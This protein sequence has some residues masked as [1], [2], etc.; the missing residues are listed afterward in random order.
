MAFQQDLVQTDTFQTA[1]PLVEGQA[2]IELDQSGSSIGAGVA[3]G[4]S[5]IELETIGFY[6]DGLSIGAGIATGASTL[7]LESVA[8]GFSGI[9]SSGES[10]IEF[11]AYGITGVNFTTNIELEQ[12][13]SGFAGRVGAAD[14]TIELS[15]SGISFG[16]TIGTGQSNIEIDTDGSGSFTVIGTGQS[17]LNIVTEGS[18]LQGLVSIGSSIIEIDIDSSGF[19]GIIGA[20]TSS[21]LLTTLGLSNLILIATDYQCIVINTKTGAVSEY[22]NYDFNSFC[23]DLY[24]K[25]V[26]CRADGIYELD[27]ADDNGVDID[28]YVKWG[29]LDPNIP[30]KSYPEEGFLSGEST[31][32]IKVTTICDEDQSCEDILKYLTIRRDHPVRIAKGFKGRLYEVKIE[33]IDGSGFTLNS[34]RILARELKK[35]R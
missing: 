32:D 9:V 31:G 1:Y 4:M 18:A 27:G 30:T 20:G 23:S 25:V 22:D 3:T 2:N 15:S 28:A 29:F 5:E 16:T 21:I 13:G 12:S 34:Y 10:T 26:G 14:A 7:E 24:G 17:I 35:Q 33:N 8:S 6:Q 11:T 19:S